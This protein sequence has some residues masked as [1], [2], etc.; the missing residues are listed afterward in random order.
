MDA[1]TQ[2]VRRTALESG[3]D[4]VGFAPI[5]RF[6]DA[7]EDCHPRTILP[8]TRS[9][10]AVAVR[11]PRGTLKAAEEGTYF[12]AYSA[13]AY[14]Y[15]NE[16]LAI[17]ILRGITMLLEEEGCTSVPVH[18]PFH[19]HAGRQ[20][21]DDQLAG[22]DGIVSL[23]V[24]GVAAGLGELGH[25]KLL[26]TPQFGPRQRV[27]V[28][29]TDAELE[30]TPL[31]AGAVCDGCMACV[32]ECEA[33][34]IGTERSVTVNIDGTEYS[35][36]PL[37]AERCGRVH[38]GVDRP[39]SPFWTGEEPEGEEPGYH[40]WLKHR[41]RHFSVCVG[42]GCLRACLDH[43]EKT[44]RIEASFQTPLIERERYRF[45]ESGSGYRA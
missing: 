43:L 35:H 31:F 9:V 11:Q 5:S 7:P 20:L 21:R 18:N 45:G 34:A 44:G 33:C 42:R 10:V 16:V 41:F 4:L 37:D 36:A 22:P 26:L 13:D 6:D 3:A 23:R 2:S 1:L 17:Q 24:A 8:Q 40:K 29:L 38:W 32:R 12:Q 39:Y 25:S 30:P 19:P 27:F 14:W 28:V 15:L